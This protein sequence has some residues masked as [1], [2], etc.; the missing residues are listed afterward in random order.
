MKARLEGDAPA[1]LV[2]A[3]SIMPFERMDFALK[4]PRIRIGDQTRRNRIIADV[5]PFLAVLSTVSHLRIPEVAKPDGFV[6]RVGPSQT[7][8]GFPETNPC[9]QIRGFKEP[10]RAK[11]ME[12]VR[13]QHEAANLPF[14]M[15]FPQPGQQRKDLV[16]SEQRTAIPRADRHKDNIRP[17]PHLHWRVMRR[18]LA[19]ERHGP[20][21]TAASSA[22]KKIQPTPRRSSRSWPL[23]GTAWSGA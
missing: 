20:S 16:P 3:T 23:H 17:V 15:F 6:F 19:I 18:A 14:L 8:S 2:G 10:R 4:R 21:S 1:A 13:H 12:V 22:D 5:V 9:F 11:K 7:G